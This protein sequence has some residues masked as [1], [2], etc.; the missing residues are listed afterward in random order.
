MINDTDTKITIE[1]AKREI[2]MGA[3]K[4]TQQEE[5]V[6]RPIQRTCGRA[7]QNFLKEPQFI[8]YIQ[9]NHTSRQTNHN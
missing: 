1:T 8:Y 3:L 2:E 5:A 7:H 9:K 6:S 4:N